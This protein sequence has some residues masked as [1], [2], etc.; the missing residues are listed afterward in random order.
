MSL[1]DQLLRPDWVGTT[2]CVVG[3]LGAG[4]TIGSMAEADF[5]E[6]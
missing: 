2:Y 5:D 3:S 1:G 4:E 6:G